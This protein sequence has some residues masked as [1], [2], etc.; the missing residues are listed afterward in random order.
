MIYLLIKH[1]RDW[2]EA[3]HLGYLRVF[4][5]LTFQTTL[6]VPMSFLIVILAG[7]RVIAWLRNQKIK[8]R[9][10]VDQA[11]MNEL[12]KR[13]EGGPTMGGILIISAITMTTLLFADLHNFYVKM[14]LVCLLWLGAVG[15]ADDWLK[16]T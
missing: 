3:H 7:P 2:L 16:L 10:E 15:A 8:D 14:A 13:T 11:E 9:P 12:M 4:T 5:Y 1:F 6:A